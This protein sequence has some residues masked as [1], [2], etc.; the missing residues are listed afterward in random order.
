MDNM[1]IGLKVVVELLRILR[2]FV[3]IIS[4]FL[5]KRSGSKFSFADKAS[6]DK[7]V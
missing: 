7:D 5:P 4:D 1:Q 6:D 2:S 3:R